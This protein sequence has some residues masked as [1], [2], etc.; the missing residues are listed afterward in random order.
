MH[1]ATVIRVS[2]IQLPAR[3]GDPALA[4]AEVDALLAGAP[5]DIA[6]LP[7][8]SLTGYLSPA[9]GSDLREFA[10]TLSGPTTI[11]LAALARKH[12]VYLAAPLIE[13]DAER[14]YNAMVVFDRDGGIVARYRKRHPWFP[15]TWATPGEEALPVFD[16]DGARVTIAICF[17]LHFLA[18]EST[19]A[20]LASDV[21]LFPSA[22][23]DDTPDDA[24]G[25][26]LGE[27]ALRFSIAVVNANW[28]IGRPRVN[29]QGTSRILSAN[30]EVLARAKLGDTAQRIDASFAI[31]NG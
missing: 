20:L 31:S 12:S 15:E 2:A 26:L 4:L 8:A 3:F 13:R 7:E 10:E 18:T 22:W 28:G 19:S 9:G 1:G 23:V 29:G 25:V 11:A 24:R 21:L 30:G 27:L 14:F 5:T 17:D 16:V 6:L